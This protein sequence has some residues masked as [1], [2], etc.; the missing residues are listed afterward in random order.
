MFFNRVNGKCQS[1]PL[2]FIT[3]L[4]VLLF[5]MQAKALLIGGG[6]FDWLIQNAEIVIKAEVV[7]QELGTFGNIAF[8]AKV[9]SILKSDGEPIPEELSLKSAISIWPA[10]LGVPF[11]KEQIVILVLERA[12]GELDVVNNTRAALPATQ[13]QIVHKGS[14]T[15]QKK[16][17]DELHAFLPKAEDEVSQAL[18]LVHLSYLS[19]ITD[20]KIFLPYENSK[21]KW[22]QRGVTAQRVQATVADFEN[23]LAKKTETYLKGMPE[24]YIFWEIYKDIEWA[25]RCGGSGDKNMTE[26]A[27]AYL[28]IYRTIIDNAPQD[29]QRIHISIKALKTIG[30]REDILRLYKYLD[31]EKAWMRHNVLEGL[32]RIL[33]MDIKRPRITSYLMP[34]SRAPHIQEW[35]KQTRAAIRKALME[36]GLIEG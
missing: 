12:E 17:F 20:E 13:S 28:P 36:E 34:E 33:G 26:R 9:I 32:G 14:S 2:S 15:I 3:L 21:N 8:N 29:Y 10:D 24:D 7:S 1:K 30:G 35:E 11:E 6:R 18:I 16:V 25:S 22:L 5:N 4:V 27:I 31:H 23:H 19:S